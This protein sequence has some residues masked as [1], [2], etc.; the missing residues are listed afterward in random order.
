MDSERNVNLLS[1][2]RFLVLTKNRRNKQRGIRARFAFGYD[3]Q[4]NMRVE[5]IK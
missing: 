1:G 5:R 3:S 4:G 2:Q